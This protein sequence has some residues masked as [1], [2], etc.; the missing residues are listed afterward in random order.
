MGSASDDYKLTFGRAEV[1][2]KPMLD[3]LGGQYADW[4]ANN[5]LDTRFDGLRDIQ[6]ILI[7]GGNTPLIMPHL[8]EWYG[9][10]VIEYTGW[11]EFA[12]LHPADLNAAGGIR[13]ALARQQQGK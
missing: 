6:G 13:L 9:D 11:R 8:K 2:V 5:A 7:I 1:D 3:Y 4:L 10:K 12:G